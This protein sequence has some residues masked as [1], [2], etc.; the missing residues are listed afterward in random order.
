MFSD[1]F[2][3]FHNAFNWNIF[4]T[5]LI[6]QIMAERTLIWLSSLISSIPILLNIVGM[7]TFR[8]FKCCLVFSIL[9][10][11]AIRLVYLYYLHGSSFRNESLQIICP[12]FR[13]VA[14]I[15]CP[16]GQTLVLS[17]K[18]RYRP[19][20]FSHFFITFPSFS[21][22][23]PSLPSPPL[24]FSFSLFF[25]FFSSFLLFPRIFWYQIYSFMK[26]STMVKKKIYQLHLTTSIL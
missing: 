20:F 4:M 3:M 24:L 7:T 14:S 1:F 8:H 18:C 10:E 2:W 21:F 9:H 16:R 17:L 6:I 22:P 25:P 23:F 11:K 26:K 5:K 13:R 12:Q 15:V 19:Y